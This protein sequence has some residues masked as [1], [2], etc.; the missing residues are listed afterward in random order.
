MPLKLSMKAFGTGF[1]GPKNMAQAAG[2]LLFLFESRGGGTF[3]KPWSEQFHHFPPGVVGSVRRARR[4]GQ[5]G[6]RMPSISS[7][8]ISHCSAYNALRVAYAYS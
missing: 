6:P 2:S 1:P 3:R 7:L 8:L 4:D 5:S